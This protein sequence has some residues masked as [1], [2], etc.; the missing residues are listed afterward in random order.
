M[1]AWHRTTSVVLGARR[2]RYGYV[3]RRSSTFLLAAAA[4]AAFA[5]SAVAQDP[6]ATGPGDDPAPAPT[7]VPEPAPTPVDPQPVA[8]PSPIA[9][10]NPS[11]SWAGRLL[12]VATARANPGPGGKPLRLLQPIAPLGAGPVWLQVRGVK[13]VGGVRWVKVLM[14]VR[15]NGSTGWVRASDMVFRPID[16]RVDIDLSD[17]RLTLVRKGKRVRS[18]TVA[19]GT[20]KN[21]TPTGRFA[22]AEVIPTGDPKAF[23]GPLVLP[24]TGFSNTLNEFAGGNGRVAIHGTSEPQLIGQRVSHGCIRM[25]NA[26]V[27]A[28]AR[29]VRGGTPVIIRN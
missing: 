6:P 19:V 23:L 13:V 15:P 10:P 14:P 16:L 24:I 8:P 4:M 27:Q 9:P 3:V 26:D 18:W 11:R 28:L 20:P 21:P 17:R 5:G 25:R 29:V 22:I 7:P 2:L 1:I 12:V